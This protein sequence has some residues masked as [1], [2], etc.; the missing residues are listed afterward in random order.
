MAGTIATTSREWIEIGGGAQTK[1]VEKI[2]IDWTADAADGSVPDLSISLKGFIVQAVTNPGAT[3]P[4]DN[5]DIAIKTSEGASI[6]GS[7]LENRD[8]ATS[9]A[10]VFSAPPLADGTMTISTSG[11]SVNSATARLVLYIADS[12]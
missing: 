1:R 2:V 4:T 6:T 3:A 10:V 11:N 12:L 8:T 7:N 5:W 9:E